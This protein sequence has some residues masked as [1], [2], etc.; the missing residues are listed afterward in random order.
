M[1]AA[2]ACMFG[3]N[4]KKSWLLCSN[5][6][7]IH[8]VGV[9]CTHAEDSHLNFAGLRLADVTF[10]S[11]LTACYPDKLANA[12][13]QIFLPFLSQQSQVLSLANWHQAPLRDLPPDSCI[14]DGGGLCSTA[15]WHVPQ[16]PDACAR[17]RRN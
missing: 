2:P 8:A 10:F 15:I 17:L 7:V 6:P 4:W 16:A 3:T 1:A 9:T 11:R 12:L 13:A 5:R 14:E